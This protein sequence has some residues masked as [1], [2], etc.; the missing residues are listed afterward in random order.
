MSSSPFCFPFQIKTTSLHFP[1]TGRD[2]LILSFPSR[3]LTEQVFCSQNMSCAHRPRLVLTAHVLCSQSMCCAHRT[4]LVLTDHVLC[5]QNMSCAV[6]AAMFGNLGVLAQARRLVA[7]ASHAQGS[8]GDAKVRAS[9]LH[10][11]LAQSRCPGP[12]RATSASDRSPQPSPD[13]RKV[14]CVCG[15][16]ER[17]RS[18]D[19]ACM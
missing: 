9:V 7:A 5:S 11:V 10:K 6:S 16:G 19:D 15:G 17:A 4:C 18:P 8:P 14:R 13:R 3:V 1:C 12:P 2:A